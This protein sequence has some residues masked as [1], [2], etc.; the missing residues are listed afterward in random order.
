MS[1]LCHIGFKD[2]LASMVLFKVQTWRAVCDLLAVFTS[3]W[4]RS[5]I[6]DVALSCLDG[7]LLRN[8]LT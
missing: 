3:F 5:S 2:D 1:L 8:P 4:L 7:C 6:K